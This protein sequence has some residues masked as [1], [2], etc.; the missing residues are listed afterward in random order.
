VAR[1]RIDRFWTAPSSQPGIAG[2]RAPL[3]G[4]ET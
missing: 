2:R 3:G 4:G 1:R